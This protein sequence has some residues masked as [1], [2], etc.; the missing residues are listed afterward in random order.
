MQ[1][2]LGELQNSLA[3]LQELVKNKFAARTAYR[4]GRVIKVAEVEIAALR[5]AHFELVQ[6]LGE[7]ETDS[8]NW[9]VLTANLEQFRRELEELLAEQITLPGDPLQIGQLGECQLE[10]AGLAVLDW[11]IV[12]EESEPG[13]VN[14]K[15]AESQLNA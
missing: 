10:P 11:L 4:L 7:Q 6:R 13:L 8:E 15:L 3:A 12:D 14:G 9:T 5:T 1:I 2:S